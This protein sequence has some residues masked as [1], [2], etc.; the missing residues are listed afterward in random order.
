MLID[1]AVISEG[2]RGSQA[3]ALNSVFATGYVTYIVRFMHSCFTHAKDFVRLRNVR[4]LS[5][6]S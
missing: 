1:A 3:G 5:I 2:V 6:T 4:T